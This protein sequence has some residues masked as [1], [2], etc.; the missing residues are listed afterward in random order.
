MLGRRHQ[1]V[2]RDGSEESLSPHSVPFA[3]VGTFILAFGWF[4]F[5]AGS[6][7]EGM[8]TRIGVIATN[9]AL[10]SAAGAVSAMIA[11]WRRY[12]KP[13][14]TFMCNGLL[15]GLVAI[16]APC[17]FVDS[18]AAVLIGVSAGV[19][20]QYSTE[21]VHSKGIDDPVGAISVHG[22]CGVLG[23]LSVGVFANGRYGGGLNGVDGAV[24]GLLYGDFWQ[25]VAQF[26]G[27]SVCICVVS[28]VSYCVFRA[29]Q[30]RV[31]LRSSEK[32]QEVGLDSAELG[33]EAYAET[34]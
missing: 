21:A 17:A 34:Q 11:V 9:T 10:A 18:W 1:V 29:I 3:V 7:L 6:T 14:P 24:K 5:N 4:G 15:S 32:D 22:V 13:D 33:V 19:L 28:A 8:N 30:S 26:I 16:T 12:G 25:F 23:I 31:G 2:N 27:G 20:M